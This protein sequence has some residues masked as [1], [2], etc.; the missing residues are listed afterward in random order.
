M[1]LTPD[2]A[3]IQVLRVFK[4][5]KLLRSSLFLRFTKRRMV[6]SYRRF[7]TTYFEGSSKCVIW[8]SSSSS[9]TA[10]PLKLEP[11]GCPDTS[12]R[13]YHSTL[14]KIPKERRCHIFRGGSL[15]SR[16]SSYLCNTHEILQKTKTVYSDWNMNAIFVVVHQLWSP[17]FYSV[18]L[19]CRWFL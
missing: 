9:W 2:V 10:W 19:E 13:N 17:W 12:L 3:N 16:N 14:R 4:I 5:K 8:A 1:L 11:P 7:G 6:V 18:H 15:K